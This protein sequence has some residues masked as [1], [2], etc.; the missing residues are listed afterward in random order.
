MSALSMIAN[1]ITKT[2]ITNPDVINNIVNSIHW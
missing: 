1:E 2:I